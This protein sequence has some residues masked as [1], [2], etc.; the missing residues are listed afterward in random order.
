MVYKED[1]ID[2]SKAF[3]GSMAYS[4]KIFDPVGVPYVIDGNKLQFTYIDFWLKPE[5]PNEAFLEDKKIFEK[6]Y[7]GLINETK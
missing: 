6:Y 4:S 1:K 3:L 5:K 7:L 2:Y